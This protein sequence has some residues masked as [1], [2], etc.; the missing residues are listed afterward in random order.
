MRG[1][2]GEYEIIADGRLR[3]GGWV[4]R[5]DLTPAGP[6]ETEVTLSYDWPAVS[7]FL[8]QHIGFPP[9]RSGSSGQLAGPPRQL[10]RRVTGQQDRQGPALPLRP[11]Q[12]GHGG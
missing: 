1:R 12:A 8:R 4:W 6:S 5:Y 2:A 7:G 10:G 3:F 11:G 9:V